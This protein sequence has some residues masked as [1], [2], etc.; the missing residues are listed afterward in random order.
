MII[1][2]VDQRCKDTATTGEHPKNQVYK[3]LSQNVHLKNGVTS[4]SEDDYT[5]CLGPGVAV[6]LVHVVMDGA[7]RPPQGKLGAEL[8]LCGLPAEP[9][10]LR[11]LEQYTSYGCSAA[12]VNQLMQ[13]LQQPLG[14][15]MQH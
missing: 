11:A 15:R 6:V 14:F 13:P 2:F 3:K 1:V 5:L 9:S 4:S 7:P 8:G 12:P 10:F